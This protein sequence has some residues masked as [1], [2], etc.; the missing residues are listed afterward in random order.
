MLSFDRSPYLLEPLGLSMVVDRLR[1]IEERV[2]LLR[3]AGTITEQTLTEYY[4]QK[5][6]EQVAESNAL[7]G[8]T[9]SVGETQ[10][11][12]MK[13]ITITGHDPGYV[14]DAVALD[15]ALSRVVS[16]A[17]QRDTP[18][19]I[20]QLKEIHSLI[21]GDR[22]GAGMFRSEKVTIRG[23]QH[24]P[25]R[26]W[27]EIMV[28]MEDWERWSIENKA[29]PAPFRSAV[30]HAW[31]THIHPFIDGNGRVSRAIGNLE[32][33]RAGYPP[34]IFK[35]KERDQYLQGLSEGDIGGDI[36]SFIDLVFDRVEGSL[37]GLELSAKKA[38]NYNPVLQ[39]IIKQQEDQLSIWSTALKLLANIM[40][41]HLNS[42]L[43]KVGGKA[44]I[45]VFDGFL[46]LDDYVDLCAG[47]GISGGWAFI[48]NIQIPGVSKLDKLGYVQHRS[49]DMFHHLGREGGP[50]LYWSHTNPLGYPKWARDDNASPFAVEVTAKAGSGDEWI[51][52]LPDGSFTELS[53]TELAVR[54][55]D[56]LLSQIGS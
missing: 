14:R 33:I 36:R 39:K 26:T 15:K 27:Q 56:A 22:P 44:D 24:T 21:L 28:Q 53:T 37:T 17:R 52:R 41:Y 16:L 19:N 3:A 13:G 9:L 7:E 30:L 18:T 25:P 54:F 45:K 35:K 46:D 20:E 10:L 11:A 43:D 1:A 5:R 12:V 49:A 4:G 47:R 31:L 50:S 38:Q 23:S 40:Q 51:A 34:V 6:F 55:A 42:D 48:L 2:G 29:A 8:S 32:L